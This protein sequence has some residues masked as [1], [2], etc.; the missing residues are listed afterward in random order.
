[1]KK[2]R[3]ILGQQAP[4]LIATIASVTAFFGSCCALPLLL[5]ATGASSMAFAMKLQPYRPFL[6]GFTFLLLGWAFYEVYGRKNKSDDDTTITC[7]IKK[8]RRTRLILWISSLLAALFLAG[9]Y[10]YEWLI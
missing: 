1:M 8:M 3:H 9:P 6:V 4:S 5:M 2:H 7:S 10:V